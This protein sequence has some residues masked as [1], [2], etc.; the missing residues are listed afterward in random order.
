MKP[1]F[2]CPDNHDIWEAEEQR[3]EQ[4]LARRPVCSYCDQHIQEDY[5]FEIDC[6]IVCEEC[7]ERHFKRTVEDE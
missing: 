7:L 5:F 6:E 2:E 1:M 4:Q 3:R